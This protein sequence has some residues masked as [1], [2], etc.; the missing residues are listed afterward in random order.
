VEQ[1]TTAL[2]VNVQRL[3]LQ[4]LLDIKREFASSIVLISHDMAVHAE[5][6]DRLAIMYAGKVVEIGNAEDLYEDPLHVY[7]QDLM[8]AIPTLEERRRLKTVPGNPPNLLAPP[9]GC[10]Y[11]PRCSKVMKVCREKEPELR[12]IGNNR[13]VACHLYGD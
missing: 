13:F 4:L 7:T 9:S 8:S 3:I 10:R 12:S 2:D 5:L 6:A 11:H 1:P